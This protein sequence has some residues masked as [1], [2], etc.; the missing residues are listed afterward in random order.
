MRSAELGKRRG[1]A[2]II[3]GNFD[4]VCTFAEKKPNVISIDRIVG[5]YYY[6]VGVHGG[7]GSISVD[8]PWHVL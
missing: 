4:I 6:N 1:W 3:R 7:I 8:L 5:S 2:E